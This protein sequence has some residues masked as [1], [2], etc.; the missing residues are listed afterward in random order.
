MSPSFMSIDEHVGTHILCLYPSMSLVSK[1]HFLLP[2][3]ATGISVCATFRL[4]TL[5]RVNYKQFN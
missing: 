4:V 3:S 5:G 2:V 1:L